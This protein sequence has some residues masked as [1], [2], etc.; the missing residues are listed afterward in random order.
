MRATEAQNSLHIFISAFVARIMPTQQI[1]S[2]L[3]QFDWSRAIL[4]NIYTSVVFYTIR[5]T[6]PLRM[7]AS[8]TVV[9]RSQTP[10]TQTTT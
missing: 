3:A 9:S 5:R 8:Y 4:N 6:D 2:D 10:I 7:S 1:Y